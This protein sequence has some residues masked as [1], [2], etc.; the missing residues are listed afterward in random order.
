LFKEDISLDIEIQWDPYV[1]IY[2][3]IEY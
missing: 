2:I 1:Y 3:H